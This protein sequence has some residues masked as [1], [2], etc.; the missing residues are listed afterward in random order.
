MGTL[1]I[2]SRSDGIKVGVEKIG[3]RV[4]SARSRRETSAS[5]PS[6]FS[7]TPRAWTSLTYWPS[8]P[9][10]AWASAA[11]ES[12]AMAAAMRVARR[13]M[14]QT[15]LLDDAARLKGTSD[16]AHLVWPVATHK[17]E[18]TARRLVITFVP[19][20]SWETGASRRGL[21]AI[22][23]HAATAKV[24]KIT[25]KPNPVPGGRLPSPPLRTGSP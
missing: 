22:K 21:K 13:S 9:V 24:E 6:G 4:R 25:P 5:I 19:T 17:G 7:T 14:R 8:F 10:S 15:S 1:Q 18:L 20:T 23:T 2:K 12:S 16:I 11:N 3:A